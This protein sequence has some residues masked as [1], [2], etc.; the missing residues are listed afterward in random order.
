MDQYV[1]IFIRVDFR[2]AIKISHDL[3][4]DFYLKLTE[5]AQLLR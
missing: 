2:M 4:E 1:H 5:T 3:L